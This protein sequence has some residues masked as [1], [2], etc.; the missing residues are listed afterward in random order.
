MTQVGDESGSLVIVLDDVRKP[1]PMPMPIGACTEAAYHNLPPVCVIVG[2]SLI[3]RLE[4]RVQDPNTCQLVL[5]VGVQEV[6][7]KFCQSPQP[8]AIGGYTVPV[9]F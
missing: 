8:K 2:K 1:K 6:D 3:Y 9:S 7:A 5:P 4:R